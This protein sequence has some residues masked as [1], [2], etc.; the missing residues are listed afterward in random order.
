M[1][2]A[3]VVDLLGNFVLFVGKLLGTAA[4][5]MLTVGVVHH[6]GRPISAVTVSVVAV[7]A[8]N[9][10]SLFSNIVQVGV[11]TIMICYCED[12]ERNKDGA[13]YMS[14]ELH[15]LL[16][17]KVAESNNASKQGINK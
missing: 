14:P 5:T 1:F 8:Y 9:V 11:D 2:S 13:L 16:Q 4:V 10:F 6:L 12:M 15:N 3:V 17:N 7:V